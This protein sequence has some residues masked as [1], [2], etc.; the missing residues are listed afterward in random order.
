M[1]IYYNPEATGR[2]ETKVIEELNYSALSLRK[3]IL[4][5]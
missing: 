3:I 5:D 4:S 2:P 1:K